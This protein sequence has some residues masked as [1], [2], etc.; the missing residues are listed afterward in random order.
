MQIPAQILRYLVTVRCP[1]QSIKTGL[2]IGD[3]GPGYPLV[4]VCTELDES[5]NSSWHIRLDDGDWQEAVHVENTL[6]R[7]QRG[8]RQYHLLVNTFFPEQPVS[9]HPHWK[10]FDPRSGPIEALA[11]W[12]LGENHISHGIFSVQTIPTIEDDNQ[13]IANLDQILEET[14]S[15]L[16]PYAVLFGGEGNLIGF[17]D[18]QGMYCW[19]TAGQLKQWKDDIVT[20]FDYVQ[21]I[22]DFIE[23][24]TANDFDDVISCMLPKTA[25]EKM[26]EENALHLEPKIFNT[27]AGEPDGE[28]FIRTLYN[29]PGRFLQLCIHTI[30]RRILKT[31]NDFFYA[32]NRL[33]D[34]HELSLKGRPLAFMMLLNAGLSHL[35]EINERIQE[36]FKFF[37]NRIFRFWLEANNVPANYDNS[38]QLFYALLGKTSNEI[39]PIEISNIEHQLQNELDETT[40]E[41]ILSVLKSILGYAPNKDSAED[42]AKFVSIDGADRPMV[43]IRL[44]QCLRKN[45]GNSAGYRMEIASQLATCFPLTYPYSLLSHTGS[46]SRFWLIAV[47]QRRSY[48]PPLK[49][50]I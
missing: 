28:P 19:L 27:I 21:K 3:M 7:F 46:M 32:A 36:A 22:P 49:G 44:T 42:A 31:S 43:L 48:A 40:W 26:P 15:S 9:Y 5:A 33:F 23:K 18:N 13:I 25:G 12:H 14:R 50:W 17:T 6:N 4:L 8:N 2:V 41:R 29:M 39:D 30:R 10:H 16:Q 38:E 35:Q 37:I 47:D 1:D 11:V 24:L 45:A 20:F 34:F